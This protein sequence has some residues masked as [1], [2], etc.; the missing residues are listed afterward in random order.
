MLEQKLREA[1]VQHID[2]LFYEGGR[3]EMLN[4]INRDE[5]MQDVIRWMDTVRGAAVR[6]SFIRYSDAQ[7]E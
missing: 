7:G 4:E 6:Q 3:H 5:V 2:T 1:G